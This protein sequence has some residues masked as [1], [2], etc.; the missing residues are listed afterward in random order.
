MKDIL[1]EKEFLDHRSLADQLSER[2]TSMIIEGQFQPGEGLKEASL[3]KRFNVS[4]GP[5]REALLKLQGRR[6]VERKQNQ[7]PRVVSMSPAKLIQLFY[8][9]EALE[10]MSCRLAT[11]N[12]SDEAIQKLEQ[13]LTYHKQQKE[14]KR[15]VTFFQNQTDNDFHYQIAMGANNPMLFDLLHKDLYTLM[16]VFRYKSSK[17]PGRSTAVLKEHQ[18]ILTAIKDRN[19]EKAEYAMRYHIANARKNLENFYNE[20]TPNK[21]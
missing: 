5:L 4:R 14:L 20:P 2:L 6:L 11:I 7:S 9:R 3:A 21:I 10:G 13:T 1:M 17:S 8:I 18:N 15:T 12:L 19:A 16:K